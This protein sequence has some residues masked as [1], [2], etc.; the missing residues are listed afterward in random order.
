MTATADLHE[1]TNQIDN[2]LTGWI[3]VRYSRMTTGA[4]CIAEKMVRL[5]RDKRYRQW[6]E[7]C[8]LRGRLA[9]AL[10]EVQGL[11]DANELLTAELEARRGP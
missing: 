2:L 7:S 4:G 10:A 6:A 5:L 9:R 1:L 8:V 11:R 3:G